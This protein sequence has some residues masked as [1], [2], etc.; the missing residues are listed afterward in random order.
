MYI[1]HLALRNFR[2]YE[3]FD[4]GFS[5]L[6]AV[7][8]G[9]NG[10]GKSNILEALAYPSLCRSF[11]GARDSALLRNGGAFF[12][13][14][15][16]AR[17]GQSVKREVAVLYRQGQKQWNLDGQR[18]PSAWEAVGHVRLVSFC[19][20]DMALVRGG[21]APLRSYL[22]AV[23]L[24]LERAHLGALRGFLRALRQ[25][26]GLLSRDTSDTALEAWDEVLA[27]HAVGVVRG[28]RRAAEAVNDELPG[29]FEAVSGFKSSL[30]IVIG[31]D[32][33]SP[34]GAS[35]R[36]TIV[37]YKK[38]LRRSRERDR[39]AG[40]TT[41]GPH[42]DKVSVTLQGRELRSYASDGEQKIAALC[43]RLAQA[44][45]GG[46]EGEPPVLILDD[47]LAGLDE[48]RSD[49]LAR[50]VE[51]RRGQTFVSCQDPLRAR[52]FARPL[53]LVENGRVSRTEAA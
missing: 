3:R 39:V 51:L 6:G 26:N 46:S 23:A 37:H 22:D 49:S 30:S 32:V 40:H 47:P 42:R 24:H 7:I 33:D 5:P 2:S 41:R 48:T 10:S 45:I 19:W 27:S 9:P 34:T 38:V 43:L 4:G 50:F 53:L 17:D 35:D 14:K 20:G 21:P 25:R 12:W 52:R 15:S 36:E 31:D 29:L 18:I 11:R 1:E 28:R 44:A 16:C 8:A 13:V